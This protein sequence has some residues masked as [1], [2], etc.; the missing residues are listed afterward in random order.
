MRRME[1]VREVLNED[2]PQQPVDEP[3]DDDD[4][5][6]KFYFFKFKNY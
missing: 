5:T 4:K 6:V 3:E 2:E 1:R